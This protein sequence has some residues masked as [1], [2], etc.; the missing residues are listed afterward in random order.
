[1]NE[2]GTMARM[3]DLIAFAQ[4]HNLKLGTISDLI[5]YRRRYDN[6]VKEVA[7]E[8]V[9]S[10]YGGDWHLRTFRD[11]IS[12]A[13]HHSLS[14]GDILE[15]EP[16]MVRMHV[17]NTFT[18]LLGIEQKRVNQISDSMLQINEQGKGVLVLLNNIES[19][20]HKTENSSNIIR[21]YGI[22]AQILNAIG[23]KNIRL[24][25]NS[26]TPKLIG[27]EGYGLKISKTIPIKSFSKI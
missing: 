6:L 4:Y 12:G 3:P 17:S 16:I 5:A 8:M 20:A 7:N 10:V 22:G 21:Q 15:T 2:D 1:M 18:D 13:E 14:K 9:N 25:T 26:G 27:L 11:E 19:A 23:V 24:L